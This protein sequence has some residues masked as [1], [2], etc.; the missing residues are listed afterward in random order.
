MPLWTAGGIQLHRP[1]H[2]HEVHLWQRPEFRVILPLRKIG[3]DE[4]DVGQGRLGGPFAGR[5]DMR[6]IEV[7]SGDDQSG[8]LAAEGQRAIAKGRTPVRA[9]APDRRGRGIDAAE[10]PMIEASAIIISNT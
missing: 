8:L 4:G 10:P 3:L 5:G 6:G 2:R 9:T 1:V 7:D